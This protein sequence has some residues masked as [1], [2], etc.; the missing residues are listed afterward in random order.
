MKKVQTKTKEMS[1]EVN[2]ITDEQLEAIKK[3]QQDLNKSITNIGFV[4]TQKHSLLHEY[5]GLVE[6][7]EKYKKELEDIY[8]AINVNI[9][10]GTYTE[11]ETEEKE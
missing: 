5:A 4:E 6:D 8:G 10:D 11:I 1:Q 7:I 3:H 9:E 2:K